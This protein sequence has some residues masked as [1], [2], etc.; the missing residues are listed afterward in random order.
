[1]ALSESY[2]T[3]PYRLSFR[4]FVPV[5]NYFYLNNLCLPRIDSHST[6]NRKRI[7]MRRFEMR[8][9]MNR[10]KESPNVI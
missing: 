6:L 10:N 1:M 9:K 3:M 8:T 4:S 5:S 2:R 7:R